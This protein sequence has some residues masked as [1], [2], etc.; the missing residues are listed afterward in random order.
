MQLSHLLQGI[1]TIDPTQDREITGLTQD[2]RQ[3]KPGDLFFAVPGTKMDGRQFIHAAI[4]QG[5]AAV[6]A[7]V[8]SGEKR[9]Y[10][11][12]QLAQQIGPIASR[13]Y[14]NPSQH[15]KVIGITGTNGKTS[16]SH[17]IAQALQLTGRPCG[18][19]GTLG[20][21]FPGHLQPTH[22]TTAD[23]ITLQRIL[24]EFHSQGA[25]FVAMEVSSHSLPQGRVNGIHF[26]TAVFTNLTRD[27]LDYHG[28][29][30][31]YAQAKRQLFT[32]P[33]LQH[34]ILNAD[35]PY[36]LQWSQEL[37]DALSTY[38]YSL[39]PLKNTSHQT[40]RIGIHHAEFAT[41]GVT[42]SIHTPW[43]DG[44]LHNPYLIGR[45]NLSNLLAVLAVLGIMGIPL[46]DNLAQLA[47]L[48][49]VPGRMD[50]A[51]GTNKPL[52]VV[53]YAH[54][55]DALEQVLLVLREHCQGKLWCVLGCGGNRDRGKRPLM[56]KVA[57][58]YADYLVITDDNPRHEDP[59][60][61]VTEILQG[62]TDRRSV[63]VE[64]DRRRAIAHAIN[65]AQA[66]DSVLIAGKGHETY[67]MIGDEK[68][69][70]NDMVEAQ[71]LLAEYPL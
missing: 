28:D 58:Q 42:A 56:G 31:H 67:Q 45:F 2:S 19:I 23:A 53:D 50:V 13:F 6:L 25:K 39:N 12:P 47:Q 7:E 69:P 5:A 52:I 48:R 55:P 20:Y 66:G 29:M 3:V 22:L 14:G 46:K 16:C 35:D 70:F 60:Q 15:L 11:I 21:G 9:V 51:G 71:L 17:F 24:A 63:V 1:V 65:C 38:V 59:R 33:G 30:N 10:E 49:G 27:H 40:Q 68:L 43:G 36:G 4:K 26:D 54:T 18:I 64:H 41:V 44:V 37:A 57:Q 62:L 32:W 34:A 61:I 8:G